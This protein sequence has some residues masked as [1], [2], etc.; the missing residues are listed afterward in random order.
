MIT[1]NVE[2]KLLELRDFLKG[3]LEIPDNWVIV[4]RV[5]GKRHL[6][7]IDFHDPTGFVPFT[8]KFNYNGDG[9]EPI[10]TLSCY[11]SKG[12]NFQKLVNLKVQGKVAG[13]FLDFDMLNNDKSSIHIFIHNILKWQQ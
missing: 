10:A 9:G 11:S 1:G 13:K 5:H 4:P 12:D 3:F 2:T 6:K 8:I 7:A